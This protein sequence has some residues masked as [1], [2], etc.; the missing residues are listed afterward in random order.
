MPFASKSQLRKCFAS[1]NPNWDCHEWARATPSIKKLPDRKPKR[2]EAA[3]MT[4][5]VSAALGRLAAEKPL[6]EK[7]A[8][9]TGLD[10]PVLEKLAA[11]ARLSVPDLAQAAYRDPPAFAK[12]ARAQLVP[13][14]QPTP[15]KNTAPVAKTAAVLEGAFIG[16]ARK[17]IEKKAAAHKKLSA[18]TLMNHYLD[19]VAAKLPMTKQASVRVLQAELALGKP[20]SFAIKRAFPTLSPERR[21]I[22]AQKL[23][24]GAADDFAKFMGKKKTHESVAG[25]PGSPEVSKLMKSA[26]AG[27]GLGARIANAGRNFLGSTGQAAQAGG[28]AFNAANAGAMKNRVKSIGMAGNPEAGPVGAGPA[29]RGIGAEY[30]KGLAGAKSQ[31]VNDQLKARL[32][33]A[34]G[35][36]GAG[37]AGVASMGGGAPTPETPAAAM[38]MGGGA[39]PQRPVTARG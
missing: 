16:L 27:V 21:G 19:K 14:P 26:N 38:G 30:A 34:L 1:G 37:G 33:A 20:L 28:K 15:D 4:E 17:A 24:K 6:V 5:T 32:L 36:G 18:M 8:A 2:K 31:G 39:K 13:Q 29:H 23:V 25:K 35:L 9:D 10:L 3:D 7:L 12:F 22:V 11:A